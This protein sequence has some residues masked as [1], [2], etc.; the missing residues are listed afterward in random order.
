MI[1]FESF[2][3]RWPDASRRLRAASTPVAAVLAGV[4]FAAT[5]HGAA[6]VAACAAFASAWLLTAAGRTAAHRDP[7]TGL[8]TRAVTERILCRADRR[9]VA[10]TVAVGDVD[11]L[12]ALNGSLGHAAGDRYLAAVAERLLRAV[13]K[14][15]LLVRHG[16][17]EY[18]ILAPDT[19]PADL[20]AAIGAA[21]CGP[22]RIAGYRI[23]PRASVG[24]A[25]GNG[26]AAATVMACA[27]AAMYSAKAAGGS[28]VFVYD[29]DRDGPP[30]PAAQRPFVRR[31]D[32]NPVADTRA[33]T[34]PDE[35]VPLLV[36][37]DDARVVHQALR[38]AATELPRHN[39]ST[40]NRFLQLAE[41]FR[42]LI[43]IT[44]PSR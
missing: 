42:P 38:L 17:D 26:S 8:P 43:D 16:G 30:T 34:T 18:A 20:A 5:I 21:M 36:T 35:L 12:H 9:R 33:P 23:Q 14:G 29:P 24:V 41:R 22:V 44:G 4:A 19:D 28:R 10:L 6:V 11:G 31:R 39:P 32:I 27:D 25:A 15:G 3:Q 1:I 37:A 7:L 2:G 13:P 40:P